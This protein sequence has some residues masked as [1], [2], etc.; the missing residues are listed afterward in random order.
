[1]VNKFFARW[2]TPAVF[3]RC[4]SRMKL[5]GIFGKTAQAKAAM[6]PCPL[7]KKKLR[8]PR[9]RTPVGACCSPADRIICYVRIKVLMLERLEELQKDFPTPADSDTYGLQFNDKTLTIY[10]IKD[11]HKS[12]YLQF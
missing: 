5:S 12:V 2:F 11:S 10:I 1:M 6:T 3:S 4:L 8:E 9:C 7:E